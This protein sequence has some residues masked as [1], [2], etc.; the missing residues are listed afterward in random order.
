MLHGHVAQDAFFKLNLHAITS[1]VGD[2]AQCTTNFF[3]HDCKL[4]VLLGRQKHVIRQSRV[5]A[6]VGAS[7]ARASHGFTHRTTT[8]T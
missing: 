8:L 1:T 7:G 3:T 2:I 6:V 4:F 5:F